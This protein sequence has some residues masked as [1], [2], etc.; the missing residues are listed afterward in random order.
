MLLLDGVG[1]N[2]QEEVKVLG[3]ARL[4]HLFTVLVL[5]AYVLQVIV[6]DC[7]FEGLNA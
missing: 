7:L 1:H 5:T 4:L 6:V 2:D 3:L